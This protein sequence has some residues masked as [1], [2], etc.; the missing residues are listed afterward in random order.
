MTFA[1]TM[2]IGIM[3][4]GLVPINATTG[5]S[6]IKQARDYDSDGEY[7]RLWVPE[8]A[9]LTDGRVHTPC[10]LSASELKS[11][12]VVLCE[13]YPQPIFVLSEWKRHVFKSKSATAVGVGQKR[14]RQQTFR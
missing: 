9:G 1:V 2:E 8:L 4:R 11:A 13:S 5:N 12:N 14:M 10:V 7:V 6:T 3:P